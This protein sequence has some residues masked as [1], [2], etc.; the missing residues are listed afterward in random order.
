MTSEQA[1]ENIL[2]ELIRAYEVFHEILGRERDCLVNMNVEKIEEI[3][4]EKDTVIM[5]LRLLEDERQRL[6]NNFINDNGITGDFNLRKMGEIT[7]N[8]IFLTLRSR[9]K[10]LLQSIEDMNKFNSELIGKSLKYFHLNTNFFS[11]FKTE[12]IP[13]TAGSLLSKET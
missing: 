5:R 10:S 3:S 4:K 2:K 6:I 1:I 11:S 13:Q 8:D 7:G 12:N 9:L